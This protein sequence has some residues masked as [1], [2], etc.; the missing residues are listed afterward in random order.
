MIGRAVKIFLAAL[1]FGSLSFS[2][3]ILE[4]NA[5]N[6]KTV[7][8]KIDALS[9]KKLISPYIYGINYDAD[10]SGLTFFSVK[11]GG[12]RFSSYNWENNFSNSGT[13]WFN[14][15]DN[16][17]VSNFSLAE[18]K[19]PAMAIR[20]LYNIFTSTGVSFQVTTLPMC[21]YVAADGNGPILDTQIAPS[22]RWKELKIKKNQPL[23]LEPD[24]SDESVYLDEY[25][26]YIISQY[27]KST[28][29][30]G[31]K[32]YALD[33]EPDLW[34][35]SHPAMHPELSSPEE[36]I[37][38]SVELAETIKALDKNA[39]VFGGEFSGIDAFVSY[40]NHD[41]WIKIKGDFSWFV[42]YYLSEMKNAS[43]LK[44]QRL[45]DVLDLHYYSA[46]G[47][48]ASTVCGNS[49]YSD[50]QMN[51]I[52]IQSPRTLWD[53]TY[54]EPGRV[55]E[56]FLQYLP[57]LPT[58]QASINKY[59]P[60]TKIG[61]SE[62]NFGGGGHISGGIS[63]A[64][65]LGIFGREGVY[66][67]CLRP[68]A[69]DISYQKAAINLFTNYDGNGSAFGNTSIKAETSDAENSSVYASINDGSEDVLKIILINKNQTSKLTANI[70]INS[71]QEYKSGIAYGFNGQSSKISKF[72]N[73]K[74]ISKNSFKYEIPP[75]AVVELILTGNNSVSET[76]LP[77]SSENAAGSSTSFSEFI[78]SNSVELSATEI[79]SFSLT[80]DV[81][82]STQTEKTNIESTS[83]LKNPSLSKHSVPLA[84]K[85]IVMGFVFAFFAATVYL[86]A[87]GAKK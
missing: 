2:P 14:T 87:D 49:D 56:S 22:S 20:N 12:D 57:L 29:P 4:A 23:S 74:N 58:L 11:Q 52:R 72:Q 31:I 27:G 82:S 46:A 79:S 34:S 47:N 63:E 60:G 37:A 80:T 75:L 51:A 43:S 5:E 36:L 65:A 3:C 16:A 50:A 73:V 44:R 62:Y 9:E 41:N 48:G 71:G 17:L 32:G 69:G 26:N 7:N 86:F 35:S 70:E 30:S 77:D 18:Q 21:G 53:G 67:A 54:T 66:F 55:G 33:N 25:I 24:L 68:N 10:I 38:K 28:S 40:N 85:V 6:S 83:A 8:V 19:Q 84:I 64:D 39:L 59:Y 1:I 81:S 15:S 78:S 13:K 76:V 42:D 61:F 45:L